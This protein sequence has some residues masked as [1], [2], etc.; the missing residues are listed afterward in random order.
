MIN[1]LIYLVLLIE[2]HAGRGRETFLPLRN[3]RRDGGR[4]REKGVG[5]PGALTLALCSA[6]YCAQSGDSVV[7]L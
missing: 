1:N 5:G 6:A 2:A 7:G 4:E 3:G